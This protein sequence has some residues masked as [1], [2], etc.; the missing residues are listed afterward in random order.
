MSRLHDAMSRR[1]A[2]RRHLREERALTNALS[3]APTLESAHEIAAI[4]ARR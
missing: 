1:I 4:S 3:S 2:A